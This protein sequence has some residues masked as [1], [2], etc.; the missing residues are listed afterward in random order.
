MFLP[1]FYHG[2]TGENHGFLPTAFSWDCSLG[3]LASLSQGE[4]Q[5]LDC[6]G[7]A[8][9]SVTLDAAGVGVAMPCFFS[10]FIFVCLVCLVFLVFV[11]SVGW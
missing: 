6:S 7:G 9:R 5:P 8:I 11:C 4:D 1:W 10:V 2:F 3:S